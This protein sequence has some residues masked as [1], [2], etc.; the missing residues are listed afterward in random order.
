MVY[1][2]EQCPTTSPLGGYEMF[3]FEFDVGSSPNPYNPFV[4]NGTFNGDLTTITL[5]SGSAITAGTA[6]EED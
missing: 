2:F 4:L 6:S 3:D 1:D 5:E